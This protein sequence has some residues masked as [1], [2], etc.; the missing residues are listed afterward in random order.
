M[1]IGVGG[2]G[3]GGGD[4]DGAIKRMARKLLVAELKRQKEL[5]QAA[6]KSAAKRDKDTSGGGAFS[7]NFNLDGDDDDNGDDR[8]QGGDGQTQGQNPSNPDEEKTPSADKGGKAPV[9]ADDNVIDLSELDDGAEYLRRGQDVEDHDQNDWDNPKPALFG[10]DDDGDSSSSGASNGEVQI[11]EDE[12][13]LDI[14][15]VLSLPASQRKDIIEKAKKQQRMRSRKEFMPAAA[16][17]EAYSQ[18][19]LRNFLRSSNLNKKIN[20]MGAKAAKGEGVDGLEGEAIAS[21]ATRRFIFTKDSDKDKNGAGSGNGRTSASAHLGG[22]PLASSGAASQLDDTPGRRHR[23]RRLG[24][25]GNNAD[26]DDDDDDDI[27]PVDSNANGNKQGATAASGKARPF[28]SSSDDEDDDEDGGGGFLVDDEASPEKGGSPD[29]K[30]SNYNSHTHHDASGWTLDEANAFGST[31]SDHKDEASDGDSGGGGFLAEDAPNLSISRHGNGEKEGSGNVQMIEDEML[32]RALQEAEDEDAV[33]AESVGDEEY[34]VGTTVHARKRSPQK[35]GRV[36]SRSNRSQEESDAMLAAQLEAEERSQTK[37]IGEK[38]EII[39]LS[40]FSDQRSKG[41]SKKGSVVLLDLDSDK[42][43]AEDDSDDSDVEVLPPPGKRKRGGVRQKKPVVPIESPSEKDG[44]NAS[45][46]EEGEDDGIDWEDGNEAEVAV[47]D[48]LPS[49]G[50][51]APETQPK[52]STRAQMD[53]VTLEKLADED[54]GKEDGD[55]DIGWEDGGDNVEEDDVEIMKQAVANSPKKR[56]AELSMSEEDDDI[57]WE[58]GEGEGNKAVN[59]RSATSMEVD[60][61]DDSDAK[62]K[63]GDEIG[64]MTDISR[65]NSSRRGSL[66]ETDGEF[67]DEDTNDFNISPSNNANMAALKHAEETAANLTDWAG[68]AVRRAIAA[69]MEESGAQDSPQGTGTSATAKTSGFTM[70]EEVVIDD[71]SDASSDEELDDAINEAVAKQ[72]AV[73]NEGNKPE[74]TSAPAA[75]PVPQPPAPIQETLPSASASPHAIKVAAPSTTKPFTAAAA[76]PAPAM[77]TSLEA[78]QMEH[79]QMQD[80]LNRQQRDMDTV[81]DEMKEE[82]VQLLQLF[83]IPYIEAP[84]EAEAQACALEALGLVDGVVTEDSDAFVFGG[85]KVYKNIFDDQKYVECYVASDAQRD[86]GLSHNHMIALAMLLGG[87]YTEGV[88]GVGIVNGMEVLQAFDVSDDIKSGLAKFRQWLDG[89]EPTDIVATRTPAEKEFHNKHRSARNRWIAPKDFPSP[90]VLTAYQKP[91]V[92]KSDARFSWGLPDIEALRIFCARK[93]GWPVEETDRV[94]LPVIKALESAGAR[95]TRLESYFMRYEDDIK[96]ADVKSK[97]LQSVLKK[98]KGSSNAEGKES[99]SNGMDE[100]PEVLLDTEA[101][102]RKDAK[103]SGKKRKSKTGAKKGR[104]K[105]ATSA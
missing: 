89:F 91:V 15:A 8:V 46:E 55:D 105:K 84:A 61:A 54:G 21:D 4:D 72:A 102:G 32:A 24:K 22:S 28:Y 98:V 69:H 29:P 67:A 18:V 12:E 70:S 20:E 58:D 92:D 14:D 99:A 104:K 82:I 50:D 10:S 49:E 39:D 71:S 34:L 16:N 68:R 9:E 83:G 45:E 11:P 19:Q 37:G 77:D 87:D 88:K 31:A 63:A 79:S 53:I 35:D 75:P 59:K 38:S 66:S 78:L 96:F 86:L 64:E 97:R 23:L 6:L 51:I 13:Q 73:I 41:Q 3:G 85:K 103:A 101:S 65:R 36:I 44:A 62:A 25:H 48:D 74:E 2:A 56:T 80:E 94:I 5:K 40:G 95:Q 76:S 47:D 57:A 27:F 100:E 26:S 90:S 30:R 17:P 52:A 81:T 33:V 1:T 43:G 42:N 60:N 7:S 93:I